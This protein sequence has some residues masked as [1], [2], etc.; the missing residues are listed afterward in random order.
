MYHWKR[1]QVHLLKQRSCVQCKVKRTKE[2]QLVRYAECRARP[3]QHIKETSNLAQRFLPTFKPCDALLSVTDVRVEA[4]DKTDRP[5][6]IRSRRTPRRGSLLSH[7]CGQTSRFIAV[8]TP[9]APQP[10]HRPSSYSA[11]PRSERAR[12]LELGT[13]Q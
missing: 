1:E 9:Q 10:V 4:R 8:A 12:E 3:S 5:K 6:T 13:F 11:A 2:D 7:S